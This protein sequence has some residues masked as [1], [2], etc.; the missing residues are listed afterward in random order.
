MNTV[1]P[2]LPTLPTTTAPARI[3]PTTTRPAPAARPTTRPVGGSAELG[4]TRAPDDGAYLRIERGVHLHA[5]G[6][7]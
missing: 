6:T 5:G 3:L 2:T 4:G 7:R 1:P